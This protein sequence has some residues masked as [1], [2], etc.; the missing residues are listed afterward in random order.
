MGDFRSE[1]FKSEQVYQGALE[2]AQW[3]LTYGAIGE[4]MHYFIDHRFESPAEALFAF[5]FRQMQFETPEPFTLL[6]QQWVDLGEGK[7][8]RLD[9]QVVANIGFEQ[10]PLRLAVEI[11]GHQFHE[12]SR[13]QVTTRDTRD[14][15]L[16][17]I[18]FQV[19][20]FSYSAL[21]RDGAGSVLE[22]ISM[23][24]PM[25]AALLGVTDDGP[26]F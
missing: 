20:H 26:A 16:Q 22:V 9:F 12:R 3:P 6:T 13:E 25:R 11:D 4:A 19:A 8:A 23:A 7:R 10:T 18:G 14:R 17:R 2:A 24:K 21:I 5:W 15:E 1:I